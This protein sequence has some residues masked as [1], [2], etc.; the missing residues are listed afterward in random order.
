[1][2]KRRKFV[3]CDLCHL[4]MAPGDVTV[5]NGAR[6]KCC[7]D[8]AIRVSAVKRNILS[9]VSILW[10]RG[11]ANVF[12]AADARELTLERRYKKV[13]I[14]A[15]KLFERI[16]HHCKRLMQEPMAEVFRPLMEL[17]EAVAKEFSLEFNLP[18]LL[19]N[20]NNNK[21][22]FKRASRGGLTLV[23]P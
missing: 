15:E 4:G 5:F 1:M 13:K 23:S 8:E 16:K 20:D 6:H 17:C 7:N 21:S 3:A 22:S 10:S 11:L 2:G 14:F 19:S 9:A 18:A 12:S